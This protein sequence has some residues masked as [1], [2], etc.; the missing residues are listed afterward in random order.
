M[1]DAKDQSSFVPELG[2]DVPPLDVV[3]S[4][5]APR[6]GIIDG[7]RFIDTVDD[8]AD[9]TDI[10][11]PEPESTDD[12]DREPESVEILILPL[13]ASAKHVVRI[14]AGAL[15]VAIVLSA[16]TAAESAVVSVLWTI[17]YSLISVISVRLALSAGARFTGTRIVDSR[18]AWYL[19][20]LG[21]MSGVLGANV[22]TPIPGGVG[23]VLIGVAL[24]M[25]SLRCFVKRSMQDLFIIGISHVMM[26]VCAYVI[27]AVCTKVIGSV[28]GA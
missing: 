2:A 6:R 9:L 10:G 15:A 22:P 26:L 25:T 19:A 12:E 8:D 27:I 11:L 1:S 4:D 20:A 18:E 14:A 24:F 23:G 28:V 21:G 16:V 5:P 13:L 7:P 3:T 17:L